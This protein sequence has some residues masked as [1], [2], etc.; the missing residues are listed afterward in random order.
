MHGSSQPER[1]AKHW[2]RLRI[3]QVIVSALI[4]ILAGW[5]VLAARSPSSGPIERTLLILIATVVVVHLLV[6]QLDGA[7]LLSRMRN[8]PKAIVTPVALL[9]LASSPMVIYPLGALAVLAA[10]LSGGGAAAPALT[11]AGLLM[12]SPIFAILLIALMFVLSGY[13]GG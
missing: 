6:W 12:L 11:A 10:M 2:R 9:M 8:W 4:L 7:R 13:K 1:Q 3:R 5:L